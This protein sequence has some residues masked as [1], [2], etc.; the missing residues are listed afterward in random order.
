MRGVT[1]HKLSGTKD[2]AN[3]TGRE[4]WHGTVI[5]EKEVFNLF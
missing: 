5:L 1:F 4:L 3:N 2:I